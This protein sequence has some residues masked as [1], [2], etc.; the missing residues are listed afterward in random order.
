M[1]EEQLLPKLRDMLE[2]VKEA[3]PAGELVGEDAK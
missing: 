2:W 1:T 3:R